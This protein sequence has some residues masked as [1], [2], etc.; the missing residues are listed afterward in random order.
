MLFSS[1][2]DYSQVLRLTVAGAG[3]N[4]ENPI[5]EPATILLIGL[6]GMM[7]LWQWHRN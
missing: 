2:I 3:S 6:G 4:P 1:D 7:M 5:P